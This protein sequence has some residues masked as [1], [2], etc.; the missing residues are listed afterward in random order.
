MT[1][2]LGL[3]VPGCNPSDGA[4]AGDSSSGTAADSSSGTPTSSTTGDSSNN[5]SS[6]DGSSGDGSSGDGTTGTATEPAEDTGTTDEPGSTTSDTT[7]PACMLADDNV[8]CDG[9][10]VDD[11]FPLADRATPA[12]HF[13]QPLQLRPPQTAAPEPCDVFAQDCPAGQKCNPYATDGGPKWDADGCVPLDANPS[14]LGEP[15]TVDGTNGPDTCEAGAFCLWDSDKFGNFC[16]PLCGC[17]K[18]NP[19]CD[20][21]QSCTSFNA[22]VVPLCFTLCD[23]LAPTACD[24]GEVCVLDNYKMICRPDG[25]DDHGVLGDP[26]QSANGCDPGYSCEY[27]GYVAGGCKNS[28]QTCCTPMCDLSAPDCP[29][30][31]HCLEYFGGFGL[32]TPVCLE[33][34]GY[35][36][37]DDALVD[38]SAR[39]R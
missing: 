17:S 1:L 18:V 2:A 29:E 26:C 23:P 4:T 37:S 36:V 8:A 27:E 12:L 21:G 11:A 9:R 14:K 30:G 15:C 24:D 5:G 25:S 22:G 34:V 19:T 35:C 20:A 16:E 6:S 32:E 33:D 13:E 39:L 31:S 38:T 10:V 28:A 7:G 3:F